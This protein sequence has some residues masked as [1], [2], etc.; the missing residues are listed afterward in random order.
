MYN[1]IIYCYVFVCVRV[2]FTLKYTFSIH[3]HSHSACMHFCICEQYQIRLLYAGVEWQV[4]TKKLSP[5]L[6]DI[7]KEREKKNRFGEKIIASSFES[8]WNLEGCCMIYMQ[9]LRFQIVLRKG[10]I[11][12]KKDNFFPKPILFSSSFKNQ[13]ADESLQIALLYCIH[14]ALRILC[15]T[16]HGNWAQH[17]CS[18]LWIDLDLDFDWYIYSTFKRFIRISE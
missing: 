15:N 10:T 11:M 7:L 12:P 3:I 1:W 18:H 4:W 14:G 5:Q 16:F 2:I 13:L 8:V 9:P 17:N 6:D